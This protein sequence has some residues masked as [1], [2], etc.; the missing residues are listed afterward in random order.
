MGIVL[1]FGV[2]G[3]F[4]ANA[5]TVSGSRL[6][7]LD[8]SA[9][10]NLPY[11]TVKGELQKSVQTQAIA[12][13]NQIEQW[14]IE[15][16]PEALSTH[17]KIRDQHMRERVFTDDSGRLQ[18]LKFE[19]SQ[20]IAIQDGS[21]KIPGKLTLRGKTAAFSPECKTVRAANKFQVQCEGNVDLAA[22]S[23]SPPEQLGAKVSSMISIRF[24]AEADIQ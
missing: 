16:S 13:G 19:I 10:T 14:S 22:H 20:P 17:M 11:I 8:F 15:F 5:A 18:P 6:N 23:V 2:L 24:N 1:I 9:K 3:M 4:Q 21:L 7:S 12:Q